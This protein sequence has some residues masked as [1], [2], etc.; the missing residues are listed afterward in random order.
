VIT[1]ELCKDDTYRK[2]CNTQTIIEFTIV[3]ISK[4]SDA[5]GLSVDEVI[6]RGKEALDQIKPVSLSFEPIHRAF[7]ASVNVINDIKSVKYLGPTPTETQIV[8]QTCG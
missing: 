7:D 8:H 5:A 1:R 2:Q 4:I 6:T 3:A